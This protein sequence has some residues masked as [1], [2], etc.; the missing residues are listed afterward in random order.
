MLGPLPENAGLLAFYGGAVQQRLE[1]TVL[2]AGAAVARL[3]EDAA[4][5]QT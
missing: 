3:P 2:P 4:T 5:P 1:R